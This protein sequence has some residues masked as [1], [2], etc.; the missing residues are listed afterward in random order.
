M[1]PKGFDMPSSTVGVQPD[2]HFETPWI[3][4]FF[5]INA[6]CQT[7]QQYG[8][9]AD[10]PT[11]GLWPGRVYYDQ[12]LGKPVWVDQVGPPIVWHDASGAVV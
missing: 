11:K 2:R 4:W 5:R 6:I 12:T 7:L 10:R 3:G 9:T 1:Q 8:T